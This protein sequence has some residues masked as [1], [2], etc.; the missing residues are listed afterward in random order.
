MKKAV[1]LPALTKKA[2]VVFN[3]YIR[4][5]DAGLGCISCGGSVD[6]AGHYFAAGHYSALKFHTMNVNGQCV[7]CNN[8]KHGNLIHY[9]QGLVRKYGA[10]NVAALENSANLRKVHKWSRFELETIIDLYKSKV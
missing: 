8:Y 9:R 5:R 1:P 7:G 6:H 2:V 10:D 3:G 4:R